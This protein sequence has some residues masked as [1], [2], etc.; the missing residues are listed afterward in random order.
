MN[1]FEFNKILAAVLVAMLIAMLA[2]FVAHKVVSPEKLEKNVFVVEGAASGAAEGG[3]AA[4][5]PKGPPP[6][7]PLLEK[8][9]AEAGQKYARVCSTCHSV[10]QGDPAMIGPNL[11]AVAGAAHAHM[12]DYAYSDAMKNSKGSWTDEELNE[13]LYNPRKHIP[14]TKMTFA[15]IKNDQDRANVIAWLKTLK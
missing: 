2:G 8:A 15:G 10:K 14:G 6:I 3:T 1:G 9:S 11:W 7:G 13:F 4:E 5:A 12:A